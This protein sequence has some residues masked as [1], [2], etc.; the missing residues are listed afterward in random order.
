MV[1]RGRAAG[2]RGCCLGSYF[3][4]EHGIVSRRRGRPHTHIFFRLCLE[5]LCKHSLH[6]GTDGACAQLYVHALRLNF[7]V[8]LY[9][10]YPLLCR[11][12]MYKFQ[13]PLC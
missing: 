13:V 5:R 7:G 6:G 10:F 12:L 3:R 4:C 1:L 11:L 2:A 9:V 8:F